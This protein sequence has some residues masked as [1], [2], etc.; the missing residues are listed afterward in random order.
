MAVITRM[1]RAWNAFRNGT[2]LTTNVNGTPS[3]V[4][5]SS[6]LGSMNAIPHK[7]TL[8]YFNDKTIIGSIY[9]RIAIDAAGIEVRHTELDELGRY[10]KD[11]DSGLSLCFTYQANL[12]QAPR[13]FQ[14]D[15][16]ATMIDK[17]VAVIVPV[18][19]ERD[20][21]SGEI[22]NIKTMRVG[23]IVSWH[24]KHV[25][26]NLYN[27][28]VGYREQITLQKNQVAIVENPFYSVMNEP[29]ST[30]QRLSRKLQLL[31]VV[32]EQSSSGKLDLIIQLPYVVKT[33]AR[34]LQAQKRAS[35]IEFQLKG[36]QYG[37]AYTDGTEKITQLNRPAENNLLT[38]VEYLIKLLHSQLGITEEIMNGKAD[39]ATMLNYYNRTIEPILDA[40]VQAIQRSLVG[41]VT[42]ERRH[43]VSYFKNPFKFVPLTTLA[44]IADKFSRNEILSPNEIRGFLGLAPSTDPK[45]DQLNNS[46]MPQAPS[47][48]VEAA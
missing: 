12:D 19:T 21:E 28:A 37:I 14:Q 6:S 22:V 34:R 30:V 9:N 24:P 17:G 32:D 43:K 13:A 18:D 11:V 47:Q 2:P 42:T 7:Q 45:A 41:P 44:D 3:T 33:E 48:A 29:S 5:S 15:A 27:E 1:T 26:V 23:E 31:D 25:K 39:E 16:F 20:A 40:Y 36:S 8:R 46:N 4:T 10:K 38:Q 35:D